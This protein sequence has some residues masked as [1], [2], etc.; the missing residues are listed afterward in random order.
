MKRYL[1]VWAFAMMLLPLSCSKEQATGSDSVQTDSAGPSEEKPAEQP[2]EGYHTVGLAFNIGEDIVDETKAAVSDAGV[3]TWTTGDKIAVSAYNVTT[4]EYTMLPFTC[5]AGG[6]KEGHFE[7]EVPDGYLTYGWAVFPYDEGHSYNGTDLTVNFASAVSYTSAT[8]MMLA[9]VNAHGTEAF[10]HLG[11]LLEITYNYVPKGT[12]QLVV[13]ADGIAGTYLVNLSTKA[14][15][16]ASTTNQATYNFSAL[17]SIE[18][19][20]IYVMMPPGSRT[21]GISLKRGDETWEEAGK[22]GKSHEYKRGFLTPLPAIS[23]PRFS[24]VYLLGPAFAC[25]WDRDNAA[26]KMAKDGRT[27]TWTGLM[28]KG[29]NFR[30]TVN[31]GDWWPSIRPY[32]GE[33]ESWTD[34][35][36][37]S[38]IY[39]GDDLPD[40]TGNDK[41]FRVNKD[42]N[43]TITIDATDDAALKYKIKLNEEIPTPLYIFGDATGKDWD[44]SADPDYAMTADRDAGF[45]YYTWTG[46]T[47][48]GAFKFATEA[49]HWD[50]IWNRKGT[51]GKGVFDLA[52]RSE[53]PSGDDD[54]NFPVSNDGYNLT[55]TCDMANKKIILKPNN[56]TKLYLVGDVVGGSWTTISYPLSATASGSGI[57]TGRYTLSTG[58]FRFSLQ[59]DYG[60]GFYRDPDVSW[61][62]I[63]S[64]NTLY[65]DNFY[66]T[67]AG[68]YDITVNTN[69]MKVTMTLDE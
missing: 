53:I 58:E 32:E 25:S 40:P 59:N 41:H 47:R 57:Y 22:S 69:T 11:S 63:F 67:E 55:V 3:F 62:M 43:Y 28:Q 66:N 60:C 27:Y 46:I 39:Y 15:T 52:Y 64:T 34:D 14:L 9:K 21:I 68:T 18:T 6:S 29:Q 2:K 1:F 51:S 8:P 12:N 10:Q 65:N 7:A 19:K 50:K 31:N 56:I 54:L 48:P 45:L 37:C 42:G 24:E 20:T 61:G 36:W 13:N 5:Q 35:T 30:F 4:G 17:S 16:A 23:L 44:V 49:G 26:Y 38:Y 33:G